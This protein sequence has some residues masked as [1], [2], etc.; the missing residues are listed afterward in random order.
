MLAQSSGGSPLNLSTGER[1]KAPSGAFCAVHP[2]V[3]GGESLYRARDKK[4]IFLNRLIFSVIRN[5]L[6]F[7]LRHHLLTGYNSCMQ[8]RAT[9][10]M[11]IF[12]LL[13]AWT[14]A[15][16]TPPPAATTANSSEEPLTEAVIGDSKD[17]CLNET[18]VLDPEATPPVSIKAEGRVPDAQCRCVVGESNG[19]TSYSGVGVATFKDQAGETTKTISKCD[20]RGKKIAE[21]LKGSNP[22]TDL[23]RE[24]TRAL[25]ENAVLSTGTLPAEYNKMFEEAGIDTQKL[26]EGRSRQDAARLI[27]DLAFGNSAAQATAAIEAGIPSEQLQKLSAN[28]VRLTPTKVEDAAAT[29]NSNLTASERTQY[30]Q[31]LST[32][33]LTNTPSPAQGG[34]GLATTVAPYCN[35][36]GINSCGVACSQ[37]YTLT[38]RTNNP[39]AVISSNVMRSV[40]C[41]SC[42]QP[43]N[44]ACCPSME[45]GV[46]G[47]Y[48][49]LT[50]PGYLGGSNNTIASAVCK[51]A[52]PAHANNDCVSYTRTVAQAVGISPLQTIDPNDTQ[53]VAKLMMA[54][55]RVENGRGAIFTP[56][57]LERGIQIALGD[58]AIPSGTPGFQSQFAFGQV[59][60]GN[61]SPFQNVTPVGG[62]QNTQGNGSFWGN[63]FGGGNGGAT[64]PQQGQQQQPG[65]NN[66]QP[67]GQTGTSPVQQPGTSPTQTQYQTPYQTPYTTPSPTTPT[68][69]VAIDPV[70]V[71]V[72]QPSEVVRG[73]A[74]VV[75][76]STVGMSTSEVCQVLMEGEVIAEGNEGSESV[77]TADLSRGSIDFTLECTA[78]KENKTVEKRASVQVE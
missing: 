54:M 44:A 45:Q 68:P 43:N 55:S 18:I 75:S 66:Q 9:L 31:A 59:A 4:Q 65:T 62:G 15:A 12:L 7:A 2:V 42:G 70:A 73:R 51:W 61:V 60:G 23:A 28:A 1:K 24:E 8:L 38:C 69:V 37:A 19:V 34:S 76:W 57:Q 47:M 16:E 56:E 40:G 20:P 46:A 36:R 50:G 3:N 30:A 74:I 53:T 26:L 5:R 21:S 49:L 22:V 6:R 78:Q 71:L 11:C 10:V 39:G 58:R 32:F 29:F 52:P 25:V 33:T 17:I 41:G 27:S 35:I 64:N 14:N 67:S 48:R 77:E 13:P 72:A 63:W